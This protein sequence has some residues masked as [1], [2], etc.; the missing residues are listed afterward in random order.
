MS[1]SSVCHGL[2]SCLEPCHTEPRVLRL[3]L[4]PPESN[5]SQTS[6]W[7]TKPCLAHS[8]HQEI[9]HT[10]NHKITDMGGWSFLQAL[11]DTSNGTKNEAQ[12]EKTYVQ[13]LVKGYSSKLSAK[14]LEMCT[15]SLGSET[16]NNTCESSED[17]DLFSLENGNCSTK[18]LISKANKICVSKKFNRS[19]S[20]PPPLTSITDL[21]GVQVRPHREDGRLVL[22]AVTISSPHS[23]VHAERSNGRLRIRLLKD[24]TPDCDNGVDEKEGIGGKHRDQVNEDD[25]FE[26]EAET[27]TET[28]NEEVCDEDYEDETEEV[29]RGEELDGVNCNSEGEIEKTKFPRPSR[30]KEGGGGNKRLLNWE[31]FCVAT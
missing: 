6:A 23:Y 24:Y 12:S 26:T 25:G 27:E 18:R 2:Q 19:H 3:K 31:P 28:E 10:T 16:G 1:A 7:V 5:F 17:I 11:T 8:D 21:G 4:A 29:N 22:K 9:S 15:E 20:F 30:C 13:P 14:S